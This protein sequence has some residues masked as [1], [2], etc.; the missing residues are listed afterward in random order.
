MALTRA[1][2][3]LV[4]SA[5]VKEESLEPKASAAFDTPIAFL[6]RNTEGTLSE[7]GEH[8]CGSFRTRVVR[9]DGEVTTFG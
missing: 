3:W 2:E 1:R 8:D 4:L 6:M 7:V 5:S 9:V